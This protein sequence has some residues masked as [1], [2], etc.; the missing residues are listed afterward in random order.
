V[1]APLRVGD[2]PRRSLVVTDEHIE[3][4]ARLTGDRDP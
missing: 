1:G 3:R 4:F 2:T